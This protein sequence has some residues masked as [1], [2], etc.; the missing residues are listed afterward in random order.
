MA[1]WIR[2]RVEANRKV[3]KLNFYD[4][5]RINRGG[6]VAVGKRQLPGWSGSLM[7]YAFK[8]E[9]HGIVENYLMG[10]SQTLRCPECMKK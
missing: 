9:K 6:Q 2:G 3:K 4:R 8:C 10:H 7:F 5:L 1:A